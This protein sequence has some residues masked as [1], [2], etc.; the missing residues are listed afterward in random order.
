M[1]RQPDSARPHGHSAMRVARR[2]HFI[3]G[4]AHIFGF[5]CLGLAVFFRL[6]RLGFLV[7]GLGALCI[8]SA[9]FTTALHTSICFPCYGRVCGS[10]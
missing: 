4:G 5:T 7:R 2:W 1:M 3:S 6:T 10:S 9:H 8:R